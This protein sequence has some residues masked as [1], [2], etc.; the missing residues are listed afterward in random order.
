MK[1]RLIILMLLLTTSML[2]AQTKN[3][4]Y[5]VGKWS[6]EIKGTPGGDSKMIVKLIK[7]DGKL[8]GTVLREDKDPEEIKKIEETENL[9]KIYFKHGWFTV[10]LQ[11][12]KT[13]EKHCSAK[14]MDKY[15]GTC[16]RMRL[17]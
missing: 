13:D 12:D 10:S 14:L 6:V 16:E 11:M 2:N 17:N 5:F 8:E 9:L 15:K 3:T 4:D 7:K 1:H